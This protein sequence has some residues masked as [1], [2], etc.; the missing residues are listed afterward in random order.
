MLIWRHALRLSTATSWM[1]VGGAG[2]KDLTPIKAAIGAK[3][4]PDL[5]RSCA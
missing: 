2:G 4:Q 3:P 1:R 5:G